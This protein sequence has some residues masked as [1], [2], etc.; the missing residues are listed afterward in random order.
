[1]EEEK[2]G[3]GEGNIAREVKVCQSALSKCHLGR[4]GSG[5]YVEGERR[6]GK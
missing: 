2:G 4:F 1:M 5:T 3:D 6:T